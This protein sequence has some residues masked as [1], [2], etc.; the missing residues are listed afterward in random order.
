M[1]DPARR[2]WICRKAI[3][4]RPHITLPWCVYFTP[5]RVKGDAVGFPML[6]HCECAK[7]L[8]RTHDEP[9]PAL[10]NGWPA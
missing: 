8:I 10:P 2:C 9:R 4:R 3:G 1:I 6:A 5:E 7:E